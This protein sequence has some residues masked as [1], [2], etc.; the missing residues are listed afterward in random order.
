MDCETPPRISTKDK[1]WSRHRWVV[2]AAAVV[3]SS[4]LDIRRLHDR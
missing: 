1:S 2:A 3:C 4:A